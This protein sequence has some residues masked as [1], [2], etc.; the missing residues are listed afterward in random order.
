[1][2][3][4]TRCLSTLTIPSTGHV[5]VCTITDSPHYPEHDW[6][7]RHEVDKYG[8]TRCPK[9]RIPARC[10]GDGTCGACGAVIPPAAAY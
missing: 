2:A 4:D 5:Y 8:M 3:T 7:L 10:S 6:V 9:F 1:M